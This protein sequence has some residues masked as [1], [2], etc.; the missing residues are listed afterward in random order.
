MSLRKSEFVPVV[1]PDANPYMHNLYARNGLPLDS[2]AADVLAVAHLKWEAALDVGDRA[3][4]AELLLG[5]RVDGHELNVL[6]AEFKQHVIEAGHFDGL[7]AI[8][9]QIAEVER[10]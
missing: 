10:N 6:P 5:R 1:P 7:L 9:S 8:T 3:E 4:T 2:S